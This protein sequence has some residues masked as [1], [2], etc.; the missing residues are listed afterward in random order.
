VQVVEERKKKRVPTLLNDPF[1]SF[2]T[3]RRLCFSIV[4]LE[5]GDGDIDEASMLASE[6]LFVGGHFFFPALEVLV[7][8]MI[9]LRISE[10]DPQHEDVCE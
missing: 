7:A 9:V 4:S 8:C 3:P 6:E 10:L 1:S 2:S 5:N